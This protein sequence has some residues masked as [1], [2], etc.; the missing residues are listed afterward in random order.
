M[1]VAGAG[2]TTVGCLLAA[3]L[4][5]PFFD[6]DDFHSPENVAKMSTGLPLTDSD[7][8]PWLAAL[9]QLLRNR[10]NQDT[11]LVLACS[12]LKTSYRERLAEGAKPPLFILLKADAATLARR[13]KQRRDH[14][15]PVELLA[16]Q[17][18]LLDEPTDA[19][20]LDA[21]L[22]PGQLVQEIVKEIQRRNTKPQVTA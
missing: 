22:S 6:A 21:T 16:S 5:R 7:R 1:G 10:A 2:K 20:I 19:L 13:L 18:E 4:G 9:N 15:M 17:L 12:A 14:Y 11:G 3:E 8:E